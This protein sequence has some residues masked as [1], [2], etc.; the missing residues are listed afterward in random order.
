[1]ASV[2]NFLNT[3]K[4]KSI[5]LRDE[6]FLIHFSLQIKQNVYS[7]GTYSFPE[8]TRILVIMYRKIEKSHIFESISF[9]VHQHYPDTKTSVVRAMAIEYI[10][11]K[12]G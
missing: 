8:A 9:F 6:S 11:Q 2:I 7:K 10:S 5:C 12:K 1:M 4:N 3:V